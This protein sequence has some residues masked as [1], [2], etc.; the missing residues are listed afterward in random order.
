MTPV[1]IGSWAIFWVVGGP[2]WSK[3]VVSQVLCIYKYVCR[4]WILYGLGETICGH[5]NLVLW[6]S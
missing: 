5:G 3:I 1:L 4:T 2:W 6:T